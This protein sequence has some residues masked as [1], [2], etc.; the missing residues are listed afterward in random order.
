MQLRFS[1]VCPKHLLFQVELSEFEAKWPV[2]EAERHPMAVYV[3]RV[4]LDDCL[5]GSQGSGSLQK[6]SPYL[7]AGLYVY[8]VVWPSEAVDIVVRHQSAAQAG[9]QHSQL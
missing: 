3:E 4:N 1:P 8:L 7:L 6:A 9:S 2:H 5:G